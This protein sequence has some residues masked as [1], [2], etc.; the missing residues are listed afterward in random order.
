MRDN[1][2][3]CDKRGWF[4][5]LM[6]KF[7][8]LRIFIILV[9]LLSPLWANYVVL[10][11]GTPSSTP[12]ISNVHANRYLI[13]SGDRL[14]YGDYNIPYTPVPTDAA[15]SETFTFRLLSGT[16]E[17]GSVIPYC[18]I[19]NGY[20]KGVFSF[21]FSAADNISWGQT[22]TIRISENPA[23]FDTP[24]SFDYVISA[25]AWTI[26][27]DQESNQADLTINILSAAQRMQTTY[28]TYTFLESSTGGTVLASPVGETYFRGAIYG[29]QAMAPNL[30]LVQT[31][32]TDNTSISHE[33][34][35]FSIYRNRLSSSF[36][37]T[38]ENATASQFGITP[39]MVLGMLFLFPVCIGSIIV[40]AKKFHKAE[41]GFLCCALL[42]I[43]GALMGWVPAPVFAS[44]YQLMGIYIAYLWFYARG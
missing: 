11:I 14:I 6:R 23:Y 10:A 39:S 36:V 8:F 28:S 31:L 1:D 21:Y 9:A 42:L 15:A 27:V 38:A 35:Q 34:T 25:S 22:Y 12:T 20:N 32:G 30:F 24:V 40:S 43:L 41:P 16:T 18:L 37:G 4:G 26:L 19:N 7:K 44:I 5:K 13:E 2:Q 33:T 17:I 3:P 29:L